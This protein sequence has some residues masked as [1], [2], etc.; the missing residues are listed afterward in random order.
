MYTMT[1]K[2]GKAVIM[3]PIETLEESCVKQIQLFLDH[4][5]FVAHIAI[6][7]DTHAGA[8]AVIGF[9]M[10][11]TDKVIPNVIGVDIGCGM[12]CFKIGK[13]LGDS[14]DHVDQ[15]VRA[16]VPF[17]FNAH[18]DPVIDMAQDFP[19]HEANRRARQ[20]AA[21]YS[22]EYGV[23]IEAPRY[24]MDWFIAK[25]RKVGIDYGRA[26]RSIG[27]L[28][29]GNHFIEI[30]KSTETDDLWVTIHTGSRG[31][32][33]KV[34]SY[35]Q[36]IAV[37]RIRKERKA[38][39][40]E[41]IRE[42]KR[43]MK[44]TPALG[45]AINA[46]KAELGLDGSFKVNGLEWLEGDDMVGYLFDMVFAQVY[47]E[48]NRRYIAKVLERALKVKMSDQIESVHNFIDFDDFIIRKGA[49]RSYCGERM[50]IPFNMRDGVLICEGKSNSV[51]N[52]SAPHGAGRVMSRTDAFKKLELDRFKRQMKGQGVYST[53]VCGATL[54]E[55][56]DAYKPP[57]LIEEA[58]ADTATIIDR[59]I[60]IHNM[61]D[62]KKK[63]D[64]K[65]I[66]A[67]RKKRKKRKGRK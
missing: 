18:H 36:G 4:P 57:E 45:A 28:G 31:F 42:L 48:V 33:E 52:C 40:K 25:C 23:A 53:S 30:G 44:K 38:E 21:R 66:R 15:Y 9:T 62:K 19:W 46:A 59:L 29:G 60:P 6:M 51:W 49:I 3:I 67:E 58:I 65:K 47:A 16:H 39:L 64:W 37:K 10:P 13:E 34:A 17:G 43:T 35:W 5:V 54:D 55:A 12:L 24:N 8:G 56:P 20:F 22:A 26:V 14:H 11:L 2:F 61:K 41:R 63:Q 7:A 32:G 50:I 27:T 1:G